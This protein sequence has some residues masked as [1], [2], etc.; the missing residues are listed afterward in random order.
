MKQQKLE[1][2]K[3]NENIRTKSHLY[4]HHTYK[5]LK[6]ILIILFILS[7]INKDLLAQNNNNSSSNYSFFENENIQTFNH[8]TS[9]KPKTFFSSFSSW[10]RE[11]KTIGLN[12]AA[13]AATMIIGAASWDYYSSSFEFRNEGWLD[14][15]TNYGGADKFGHAFGGYA[16]TSVY[17]SIYKR[18]LHSLH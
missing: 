18:L 5:L 15:D 17:N 9:G 11:K 13:V 2:E 3:E 10:S 1:A 14:P 8:D 16:L 7:L 6:H 4:T 12:V